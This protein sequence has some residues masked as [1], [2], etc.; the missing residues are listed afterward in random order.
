MNFVIPSDYVAHIEPRSPEYFSPPEAVA[1]YPVRPTH[2]LQIDFHIQPWSS[3]SIQLSIVKK[4]SVW[5]EV[6]P[7]PS[8]EDMN[9]MQAMEEESKAYDQRVRQIIANL[10]ERLRGDLE[11]LVR[12]GQRDTAVRK[13]Q[14]VSGEDI[15]IAVFVIERLV[16][17]N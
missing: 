15:A 4:G 7:C 14:E 3:T 16:S 11:A 2:T 8:A 9:R 12:N 1:A 6:L 17:K 5:Y 13:Y 10:A